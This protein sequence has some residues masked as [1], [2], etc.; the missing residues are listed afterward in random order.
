VSLA[1]L[2][3]DERV[4]ME[5]ARVLLAEDVGIV[6]RE[7]RRVLESE[8]DVIATVGDGYALVGAARALRPDVVVADISMPGLD[9]IS[10]AAQVMRADPTV[11]VVFVTVHDE[12]AIVQRSLDTGALGYVLK[13]SAADNLVP[14]VRAAIRGERHVPAILLA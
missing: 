1:C 3:T 7:L 5:R 8:F 9:G 13:L 11:R 12:P 2:N 6:A 4:T 14:A 10:A